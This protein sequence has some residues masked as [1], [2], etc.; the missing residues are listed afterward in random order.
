MLTWWRS[1]VASGRYRDGGDE[2]NWDGQRIDAPYGNATSLIT[3]V[4]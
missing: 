4:S 1:E 3:S 2:K